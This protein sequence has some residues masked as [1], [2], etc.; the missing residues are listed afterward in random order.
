M[1]SH[2]TK[3]FQIWQKHEKKSKIKEKNT[4]KVEGRR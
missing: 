3:H 4:V 1:Y 2:Q